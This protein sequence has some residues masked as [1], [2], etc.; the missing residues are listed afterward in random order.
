MMFKLRFLCI[1]TQKCTFSFH[2]MTFGD[3]DLILIPHDTVNRFIF[4]ALNYCVFGSFSLLQAFHFCVRMVGDI[5]L[6]V[7]EVEF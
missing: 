4:A 7:P 2:L 1:G 3:C 6:S 5:V